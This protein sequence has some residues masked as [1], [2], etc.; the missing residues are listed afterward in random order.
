[1]EEEYPE[2]GDALVKSLFLLTGTPPQA[3]FGNKTV[4]ELLLS[5]PFCINLR[6]SRINFKK[7]ALQ[8]VL[9]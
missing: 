2:K 1:M 4:S 9:E 5:E 7:Q 3:A 6:S 8:V